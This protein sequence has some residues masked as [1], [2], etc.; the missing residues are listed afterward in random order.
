MWINGGDGGGDQWRWERVELRWGWRSMEVGQ[1]GVRI[2]GDGGGWGVDPV[3]VVLI[4]R[5]C[6]AGVPNIP[7]CPERVIS[8]HPVRSSIAHK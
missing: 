3:N 7:I 8:P 6:P 2:N 4:C 1:G 5:A